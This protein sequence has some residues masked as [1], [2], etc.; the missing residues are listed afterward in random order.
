MSDATSSKTVCPNCDSVIWAHAEYCNKCGTRGAASGEF[1]PLDFG[2]PQPE[3]QERTGTPTG[4]FQLPGF[5]TRPQSEIYRRTGIHQGTARSFSIGSLLLVITVIGVLLGIMVQ[6]PGLGI[7]LALFA[8]PPWIRTALVL[9]RRQAMGFQPTMSDR[10]ALF[11]GSMFVTWVI[12]I[13]LTVA[14]CLTF[15]VTCL[16]VFAASQDGRGDESLIWLFIWCSVLAVA[17][18]V[19]FLFSYWIRARWRRHTDINRLNNEKR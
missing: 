10:V 1:Q 14:C 8:V 7:T 19:L 3:I 6:A 4:Q 13:T 2:D 15:F 18:T 11:M 9:K 5:D 16:A 17:I 12:V